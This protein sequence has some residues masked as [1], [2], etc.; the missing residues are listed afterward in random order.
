MAE[1]DANRAIEAQPRV[2]D[3]VVD[4][5]VHV[6]PPPE[7]WAEYLSPAVPRAGADH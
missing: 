4:A 5:D 2:A 6:T 7:F 3:W 1:A